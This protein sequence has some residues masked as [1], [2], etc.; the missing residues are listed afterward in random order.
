M[1]WRNQNK[2][3]IC[4]NMQDQFLDK[5]DLSQLIK[6]NN[7]KK[8]NKLSAIFFA[9]VFSFAAFGEKGERDY[10]NIYLGAWPSVSEDGDFFVFQWCDAIWRANTD[11][12]VA[13]PII[14][15][16]FRAIRPI[17]SPDSKRVAFLSD[18][19]GGWKLFEMALEDC[20]GMKAGE[21]KPENKT[22]ARVPNQPKKHF[23]I[24]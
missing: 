5:Y 18:K 12:G 23:S 16:Q 15:G 2:L 17:L 24:H 9:L 19:D 13:T 14:K 3:K 4:Y 8:M 7:L 20:E 10:S 1:S 11:G 21:I 6:M 22:S